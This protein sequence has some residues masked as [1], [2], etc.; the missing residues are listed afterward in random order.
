MS[1]NLVAGIL[2]GVLIVVRVISRQVVGSAVTTRSLVLM[3]V[4][5]VVLGLFSASGA[6]GTASVGELAF[7]AVDVAVLVVMGTLRGASTTLSMREGGLYQ[8]GTAL[9]LVLWIGTIALRVGAGFLGAALGVNSALTTAS[10]LLTF[11]VTI[12]AQNATVYLRAQRS[13]MPLAMQ[14][15]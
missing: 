12:A 8:K 6:L 4:I 11:G 14:R 5:L 1:L 3:P 15:G 13:R 10:L 9:T 7:F 2:I